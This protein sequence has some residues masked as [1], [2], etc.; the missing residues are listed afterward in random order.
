[1]LAT[2]ATNVN[3]FDPEIQLS[4]TNSFSVGFQRALSREHGDRSPL[5]RHPEPQWLDDGEL[6]RGQHLRERLPR[7]VQAGAGQPAIARRRRLRHDGPGRLQLRVSRSGHRHVAAADLPR[8]LQ[9]AEPEQCRQR[10]ALHRHELDEHDVRR[11]AQPV[12]A[13]GRHRVER[14]LRQRDV[15]HQHGDGGP[16]GELL[17]AQS[18]HRRRQRPPERDVHAVP[19]DAARGAATAVAGACS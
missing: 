8:A 3:I 12:R 19:L 13:G 14:P 11:P 10:R 4:Y 5:R 1:M 17:G 18:A 9:R 16:A 7:R 2:T 6:E 15:P